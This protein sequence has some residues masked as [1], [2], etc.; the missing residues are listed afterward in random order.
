MIAILTDF[1]SPRLTYVCDTIFREWLGISYSLVSNREDAPGFAALIS[2]GRFQ[3]NADVNIFEEGLLREDEM[4]ENLPE[5][6]STGGLP[7]LFPAPKPEF[8]LGYDLFASVFFVISRYEEYLISERDGHGRFEAKRSVFCDFHT[9]PY[10]DRWVREL[11]NRLVE[12]EAIRPVDRK[13]RWYN[14]LDVDIAFAYRGRSPVR[15]LGA[16]LKDVFKLRFS[17]FWERI[18]VLSGAKQD[19][20][21]TFSLF[22][23][24]PADRKIA[25]FQVAGNTAYDI[26]LSPGN[27]AFRE[28]LLRMNQEADLGLHPSY[29]SGGNLDLLR[30]EIGILQ[31]AVSDRITLSRQHFLRF[32][33]PETYRILAELGIKSDFSMG[34]ADAVGFR[35]GTAFSFSFFD[36]MSN[37][38]LPVEIFPITVMDSALKNYLNLDPEEAL[39]V[40]NRLYHSMV[41][42]G[43]V[44]L[45]IWHNHS[46]SD[47]GEWR[48][49]KKVYESIPRIMSNH[50]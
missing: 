5:L 50:G 34:F 31:D 13:I 2:Y 24:P 6:M 48:G 43:G 46:L 42:T 47:E 3:E 19:P 37:A 11:E 17:R 20:F 45:T 4:R 41:N 9:I 8:D 10:V 32:T 22:L 35:A 25:F 29:D 14:T 23:K 15:L 33:L 30:T 1:Q 49:W 26:N 38:V 28:V 7:R 44:F 18:A 39:N 12:L 27:S 36:L 21:D 16:A 40:L